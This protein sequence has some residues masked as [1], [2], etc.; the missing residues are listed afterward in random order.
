MVSDSSLYLQ[1]S[2]FER[3]A[4]RATTLRSISA[5]TLVSVLSAN[6]QDIESEEVVP[7]F[8][9]VSVWHTPCLKSGDS[10]EEVCLYI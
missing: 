8:V 5:V 2:S 7:A 9:Q 4:T 1:C 10:L 3:L 6:V